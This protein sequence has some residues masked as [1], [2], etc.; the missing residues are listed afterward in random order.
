[1]SSEDNND[2]LD[3]ASL[4]SIPCIL[5]ND[6][7]LTREENNTLKETYTELCSLFKQHNYNGIL[8]MLP[9]LYTF[10]SLPPLFHL[11]IGCTMIRVGRTEGGFR[12]LGL[13]IRLSGI[14]DQRIKYLSILANMNAE[15]NDKKSVQGCIAEVLDIIRM[16]AESQQGFEMDA[17]AL[18]EFEKKL[19]LKMESIQEKD[20][21][22]C[23]SFEDQIF[24]L[25]RLKRYHDKDTFTGKCQ[26]IV[27]KISCAERLLEAWSKEKKTPKT[28][29]LKYLLEAIL[30]CGAEV[31]C[32]SIRK[33]EPILNQYLEHLNLSSKKSFS[34][35]NKTRSVSLFSKR[36]DSNDGVEK[37]KEFQI[38]TP[39]KIGIIKAFMCM[40][41]CQYADAG[42]QFS[43]LLGNVKEEA[44][45]QLNLLKYYCQANE[46]NLTKKNLEFI[47]FNLEKSEYGGALRQQILATIYE[48][49]Y[50]MTVTSHTEPKS[51]KFNWIFK[52][53]L[54]AK[55]YLKSSIECYILSIMS[56]PEDDLFIPQLYDKILSLLIYNDSDIR[57]ITFFYQL[58]Y[59]FT[60]R[61]DYTYLHVPGLLDDF[62]PENTKSNPRL[63]QDIIENIE[64][65]N[66]Q[67]NDQRPAIETV[68]EFQFV[69]FW[70]KQYQMQ[71]E[72]SPSLK[73]FHSYL[74]F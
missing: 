74:Y 24:E 51:N 3:M 47:L 54:S 40:L 19:L 39:T 18:V 62:V 7:M 58:R 69:S 60:L 14:D 13:A 50:K 17:V 31:A 46:S 34:G 64:H 9:Q 2:V 26:F 52:H 35:L 15:L 65:K 23:K 45:L 59:Y 68:D 42:K 70:V 38:N 48:K 43:L 33:I 8:F 16:N 5:E 12:E 25:T 61:A 21:I 11:I 72:L 32:S 63:L 66:D 44:F 41:R 73:I 55:T 1:M 36:R 29:P 22:K 49:L 57:I 37:S 30:A 71:K 10:P 53:N 28:D 56:S 27:N 20:P 4:V 6:V 67:K